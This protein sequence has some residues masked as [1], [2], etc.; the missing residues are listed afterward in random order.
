MADISKLKYTPT[1]NYSISLIL[2]NRELVYFSDYDG[3]IRTFT[4]TKK[5]LSDLISSLVTNPFGKVKLTIF[6]G[7]DTNS[8][9][10]REMLYLIVD[11]VI[12]N[13]Q[14]RNIHIERKPANIQYFS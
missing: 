1:D 12:R 11:E 8:F 14:T 3:K 4:D 7:Y 10:N 9:T 6:V 5:E 13:H 2:Q